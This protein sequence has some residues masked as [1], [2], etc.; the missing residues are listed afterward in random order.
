MKEE[1]KTLKDLRITKLPIKW[2]IPGL[3]KYHDG[4]SEYI[5]IDEL[6]TEAIKWIKSRRD[7]KNTPSHTETWLMMEFHNITEN[8]LTLKGGKSEK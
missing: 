8:D 2:T 4:V 6:K 3:G 1:L 7:H 5:E